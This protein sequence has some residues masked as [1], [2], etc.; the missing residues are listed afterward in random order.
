MNITQSL[1]KKRFTNNILV[2]AG[3]ILTMVPEQ[4]PIENGALLIQQT[5]NGDRIKAVGS[6]RS[7]QK[8]SYDKVVD[9]G[10]VTIAPRLIN[11]HTHLEISHLAGK[12][13]SVKGFVTWLNRAARVNYCLTAAASWPIFFRE[14]GILPLDFKAP[15]CSPVAYAEKLNLLDELT[16]EPGK[17]AAWSVVH[18]VFL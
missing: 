5:A 2:R 1:K 7:L 17:I 10:A 3:T 18:E 4:K 8:E 14:A 9:L 6:Y 16:L 12:T 11:A 15:G 13:I